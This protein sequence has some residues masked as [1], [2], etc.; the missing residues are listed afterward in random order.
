MEAIILWELDE[1]GVPFVFSA[2]KEYFS[3]EARSPDGK[4]YT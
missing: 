3:M 2:S 1:I 4:F